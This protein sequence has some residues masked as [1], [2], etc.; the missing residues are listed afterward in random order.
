MVA[1]HEKMAR[2]TPKIQHTFSGTT[3]SIRRKIGDVNFWAAA[4]VVM[5][6]AYLWLYLGPATAW[7]PAQDGPLWLHPLPGETL[8]GILSGT[9]YLASG[10][11]Y[12]FLEYIQQPDGSILLYTHNMNIDGYIQYLTMLLGSNSYIPTAIINSVGFL[13]GIYCGFLFLR[14][15]TMNGQI[16]CIFLMLFCTEYYFNIVFGFNMR[17][18]QWLGLFGTCLGTSG[19]VDERPRSLPVLF[20][21]GFL[22][23]M[24]GYDFAAVVGAT[25][26][27]LASFL[28]QIH[29]RKRVI[30]CGWI[31]AA[32]SL[33]LLVRQLQV[34]AAIG[35]KTWAL[36]IWFTLLIKTPILTRWFELP[37]IE[38]IDQWYTANHLERFPSFPTTSFHHLVDITQ[39]YVSDIWMPHL[40]LITA[41]A[42][43]IGVIMSL[44]F[45]V[46][47]PIISS[48][49]DKKIVGPIVLLSR[50]T[51]IFLGGQAI[52]LYVFA[53]YS[54]EFA[55]KHASPMLISTVFLAISVPLGCLLIL[56]RDAHRTMWFRV[57]CM[58][59]L[60][61]FAADR[62]STQIANFHDLHLMSM[63]RA[64]IPENLRR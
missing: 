52:G 42:F 17:A 46:T 10:L 6:A 40:G 18:W 51:I 32:F 5:T 30:I 28:R 14:R 50:V 41:F 22:A 49:S 23:L 47:A 54:M 11:K 56:V 19:L 59:I 64:E 12:W 35:P 21:G 8:S 53:P 36:D 43:V 37:P 48:R 57:L 20:G 61:A 29:W 34:I 27:L 25:A 7:L 45:L 63:P 38:T 3:L 31:W 24:A 58:V 15:A 62:A 13:G 4:I 9:R 60:L 16:A 44:I 1:L 26:L 33:P 39:I 55:L 2:A